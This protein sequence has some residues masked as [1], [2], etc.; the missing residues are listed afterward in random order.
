MNTMHIAIYVPFIPEIRNLS[1]YTL[2]YSPS[3]YSTWGD[4][5]VAAGNGSV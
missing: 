5:P 2:N 4:T 3:M 1:N